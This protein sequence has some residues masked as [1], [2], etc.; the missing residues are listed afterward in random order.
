MAFRAD[1][2]EEEGREE[3]FRYLISNKIPVPDKARSEETLY[4]L[5]NTYGPVVH[6]YPSWHPLVSSAPPKDIRCFPPTVPGQDCGYHGLDHTVHL[7]NA[8][9]TCP[10]D[11][12][13]RI[14]ESVENLND[15]GIA[16]IS[17][18]RLDV[19]F[20]MPDAKPVL[21]KCE[22]LR[23]TSNIGTIPIRLVLPLVLEQEIP[24]W[25]DAKV[26]E[27]WETMRPYILGRPHGS[28]SS[29][30]VDE[31][32]GQSMKNFWNLMINTGMYGPIHVG[33]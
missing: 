21:V 6:A 18:E 33:D 5:I 28:R 22:W 15:S 19:K 29:L 7:R 17:A 32:T 8:F 27:S 14:F 24:H 31:K 9:I 13:E 10:Y 1:E 30:F 3:V 12:G 11:D 20:Y 25:R 23:H 16:R 4:K 2:A 26:A